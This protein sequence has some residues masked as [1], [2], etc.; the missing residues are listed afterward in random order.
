MRL[1]IIL[2]A[3]AFES[4]F[5]PEFERVNSDSACQY[6]WGDARMCTEQLPQCFLTSDLLNLSNN[7]Y[8][9]FLSWREV[10]YCSHPG[11]WSHLK[12]LV[13][14]YQKSGSYSPELSL[15]SDGALLVHNM[16]GARQAEAWDLKAMWRNA[17]P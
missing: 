7:Q 1:R 8:G 13:I 15:S 10:W 14:P 9:V 12:S 17:K 2:F 3:C 11:L 6:R 16:M 4:R 5:L